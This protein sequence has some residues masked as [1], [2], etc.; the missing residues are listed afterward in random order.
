MVKFAAGLLLGL[1]LAWLW[2]RRVI[3]VPNVGRVM[4]ADNG[5]ARLVERMLREADNDH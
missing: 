1:V 2:R 5:T 4:L 3:E